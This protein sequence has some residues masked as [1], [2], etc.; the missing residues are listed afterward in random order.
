[1]S[2]FTVVQSGR[3]KCLETAE[4]TLTLDAPGDSRQLCQIR[5][6][7]DGSFYLSFPYFH[8]TEGL[9]ARATY[10]VGEARSR[11]DLFRDGVLT[12]HLVKFVHHRSGLVQFSQTDKIISSCRAQSAPLMDVRGSRFLFQLNAYGLRGFKPLDSSKRRKRLYI[13]FRTGSSQEALTVTAEWIERTWL[14]SQVNDLASVVG[15]NVDVYKKSLGGTF[16]AVLV[17]PPIDVGD[18]MLMLSSGRVSELDGLNEPY[19]MLMAGWHEIPLT[20]EGHDMGLLVA[21]YPASV[22]PAARNRLR[23]VDLAASPETV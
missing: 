18:R 4:A 22:K 17:R 19:L 7:A 20:S 1:M 12:S 6:G 5:F 2:S 11:L 15:P 8:V 16:K 21:A 23:S 9:L 3:V 14:E 10:K 13:G